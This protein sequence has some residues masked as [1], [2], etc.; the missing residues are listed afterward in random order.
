MTSNN[1][2]NNK[3]NRGDGNGGSL[4]DLCIPFISGKKCRFI[5]NGYC[6]NR[7]PPKDDIPHLLARFKQIPC[8]HLDECY[9]EGCLFFHPKRDSSCSESSNLG[10]KILLP[11][12]SK[13]TDRSNSPITESI[14]SSLNIVDFDQPL[15]KVLD[16]WLG[17]TSATN[18]IRLMFKA[19]NI[20]TFEDFRGMGKDGVSALERIVAN[21][22]T[23]LKEVH[24]IRVNE[25]LSFIQFLETINELVAADP[26]QWKKTDFR[27][28]K[29]DRTSDNV[30]TTI[31][32]TLRTVV[33][34]ASTLAQDKQQKV[35]E[36]QIIGPPTGFIE[37][38]NCHTPLGVVYR[39]KLILLET[40]PTTIM[41]FFK[42]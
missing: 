22:P 39:K 15:A 9:T 1:N 27:K 41:P 19:N 11:T 6:R 38:H 16:R 36:T 12:I 25:I 8:R 32:S 30:V 28:W 26:L 24:V 23:K 10:G 13:T 31:S 20:N 37:S 17:A 29:R 2:N 35:D 5:Q 40:N 4:S 42:L 34:N 21:A 33:N 18:D 7:H 14:P 3:Y